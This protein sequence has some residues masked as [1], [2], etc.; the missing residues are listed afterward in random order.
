MEV[1]IL[2]APEGAEVTA[3]GIESRGPGLYVVALAPSPAGGWRPG[4]YLLAVV[5]ARRFDRGQCL[6]ELT[7]P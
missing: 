2:V 3:A 7:L 5:V 6:A 1:R 4:C